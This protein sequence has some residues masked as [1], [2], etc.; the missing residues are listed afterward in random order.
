MEDAEFAGRKIFYRYKK[1]KD[2]KLVVKRGDLRTEKEPEWAAA[3]IVFVQSVISGYRIK[4]EFPATAC[5]VPIAK[6]AWFEKAPR[7]IN[8]FWIN[9][10]QMKMNRKKLAIPLEGEVLSGHFGHSS[11][12]A[13]YEI[14]D[15]KIV[16]SSRQIPPPHEHGSIPKWLVENQVTD[17]L[18][19]GI[20]PKA[21]DILNGHQINVFAGVET[22]SSENLAL[23]FLKGNL[24]YG[25][26]S[27]HH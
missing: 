18:A 1:K 27:C 16:S 22:D 3:A 2:L 8:L 6:S 23:N 17:V 12:F 14:E 7:I 15:D 25:S 13:F 4:R 10:K 20:G 19:G 9:E 24:K 21:V 26:N 5:F 11:Q